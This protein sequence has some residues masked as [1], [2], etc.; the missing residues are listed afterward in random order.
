M[1]RRTLRVRFIHEDGVEALGHPLYE[2]VAF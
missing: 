2:G 1:L